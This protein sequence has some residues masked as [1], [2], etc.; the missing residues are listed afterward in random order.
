MRSLYYGPELIYWTSV[1]ALVMFTW[2]VLA[3]LG[4]VAGSPLVVL[5]GGLLSC[6]AI[7]MSLSDRRLRSSVL[8]ELRKHVGEEIP[9]SELALSLNVWEPS[10][11]DLVVDLAMSGEIRI[12]LDPDRGM[13]KIVEIRTPS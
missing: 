13:L 4:M 12:S 9:I 1:F 8:E 2:A 7:A 11:R 5:G 10:F 3:Y 6:L